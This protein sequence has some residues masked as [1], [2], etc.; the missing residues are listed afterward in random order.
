VIAGDNWFGTETGAGSGPYVGWCRGCGSASVLDPTI[1]FRFSP[2]TLE[3]YV[4]DSL[5]LHLDDSNRAGGVEPPSSVRVSVNG[6][7]A[8]E[9]VVTDPADGAPFVLTIALSGTPGD[10]VEVQLRHDNQW[11]FL[12]EV[13][14]DGRILIRDDFDVPEPSTIALLGASWA[15]LALRRRGRAATC[16]RSLQT[17]S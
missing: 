4:F 5:A 14:F 3:T 2:G 12:S 9:T 10:V 13:I 16:Q 17:I 8:I 15:G 11:V 1:T 7:P 6:G